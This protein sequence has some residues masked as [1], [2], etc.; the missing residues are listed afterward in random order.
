[1]FRAS[2]ECI[3]S[4]TDVFIYPP[5]LQQPHDPVSQLLGHSDLSTG[6]WEN[7][8]TLRFLNLHLHD[9][10]KGSHYGV[11]LSICISSLR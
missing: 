5:V 1:M 9:G 6:L 3:V 7:S 11:W 10:P 2:P 4:S 8:L